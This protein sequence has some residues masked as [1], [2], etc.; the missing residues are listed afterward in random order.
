MTIE[1]WTPDPGTEQDEESLRAQLSAQGYSI[2]RYTYPLGCY[3]PD[4]T[5][6]FAK[7]EVVLSGIFRMGM[8]GSYVDLKAGQAIHVPENAIHNAEVIGDEPVICL[9][10]VKL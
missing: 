4:H 9:D 2:T 8:Y 1:Y 10:A 5:H 3:F 7:I 6:S